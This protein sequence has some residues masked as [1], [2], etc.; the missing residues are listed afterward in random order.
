MKT[1]K[2]FEKLIQ[3][4]QGRTLFSKRKIRLKSNPAIFAIVLISLVVFLELG[5]LIFRQSDRIGAELTFE[6]YADR[7]IK[8]CSSASY[9]PSCYDEEIPKLMDYISMEDAFGVTR[10]VQQK[11]PS[12][13]YCHVLGHELSAR[14]TAKDPSKWMDVVA[15]SPRGICSNGA[16]HGAFQ[17]RFRAE[18][19]RDEEIEKLL[20]D[21]RTVCEPR[22]VWSPTGLEQASCYHAVGHLTM[23]ITGA[24]AQKSV[25]ICRKV[26]KQELNDFSQ[27]CFDGV[28]MQIFQPLEPEDFALIE[29]KQPAKEEVESYCSDFGKDERASCLNESW[30][31]FRAEIQDPRGLVAFCSRITDVDLNNRCYNGVFYVLTPQFN[32]DVVRIEEFCS[33]LNRER[34]GQC[35]AN[36]A[37]RMIETDSTFVDKSVAVCSEADSYDVGNVC[38]DELVLYSTFNFKAGSGEALFLCSKMP[39]FWSEKC[40]EKQRGF[41]S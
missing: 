25:E 11:D 28:F 24:D 29:G 38:W 15:R 13:V 6:Q 18:T 4:I 9:K 39:A 22:N 2:N 34:M 10:I 17:E 32:F 3:L 8:N 7:V 12:Y 20:P 33:K 36:A 40:S 5:F 14:E 1:L 41:A 26:S 30:P 27:L 31:L 35:F 37:S 19:L 23:Y 16:I 21:L